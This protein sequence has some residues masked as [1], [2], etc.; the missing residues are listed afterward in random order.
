VARLLKAG[1][2]AWVIIRER[3]KRKGNEE[4]FI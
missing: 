4:V 2:R 3:K 1:E